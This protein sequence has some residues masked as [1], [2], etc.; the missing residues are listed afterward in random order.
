MDPDKKCSVYFML[1][2]LKDEGFFNDPDT[3][4]PYPIMEEHINTY[5]DRCPLG[6]ARYTIEYVNNPNN[7][8][9]FLADENVQRAIKKYFDTF[10][11]APAGPK[12]LLPDWEYL[13]PN[14][15][16]P[17]FEEA[18]ASSGGRRRKTRR[19]GKVRKARKVRKSRKGRKN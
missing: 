1:R 15:P 7:K 2:I 11:A 10:I 13:S 5:K 18:R 4:Q 14:G 17:A 12:P 16:P 9:K 6:E 8:I 3:L 19:G